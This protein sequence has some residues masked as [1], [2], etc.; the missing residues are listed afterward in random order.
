MHR[1]TP[2]LKGFLATLV[3]GLLTP[4]PAWAACSERTASFWDWDRCWSG[5]RLALSALAVVATAVACFW[6]LFPALLSLARK[7]P[8][9]PRDAFGRCLA[10][11]WFLCS[12]WI[13]V[14]FAGLSDEL[15]R[16]ATR[17]FPASMTWLNWN[18]PWLTVLGAGLL[19]ALLILLTVRHRDSVPQPQA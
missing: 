10:L 7:S 13:V 1:S 4:G 15:H 16:T 6:L 8:P 12:V 5:S 9:W 19:G 11:F 14:L 3:A 18:W 2:W 17:L